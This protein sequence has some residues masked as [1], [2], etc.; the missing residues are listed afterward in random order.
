MQDE[1][2]LGAPGSIQGNAR[3]EW[4]LHDL[5]RQGMDLV[6]SFQLLKPLGNARAR[7]ESCNIHS[8]PCN[9]VCALEYSQM[10]YVI[11]TVNMHC[12]WQSD[13]CVNVL[14]MRNLQPP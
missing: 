9:T 8:R 6:I 5:H 14:S 12:Q 10:L 13:L 4:P 7:L 2:V 3:H 11:D 1:Y